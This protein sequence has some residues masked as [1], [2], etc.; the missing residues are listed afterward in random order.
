MS[1]VWQS[2]NQVLPID[3]HASVRTGVAMTNG[4]CEFEQLD[5]LEFVT[6]LLFYRHGLVIQPLYPVRKQE[7]ET[8]L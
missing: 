3:C 6:D 2:K 1:L 7:K 5:K 4:L 8:L